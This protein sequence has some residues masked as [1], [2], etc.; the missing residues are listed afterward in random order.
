MTAFFHQFCADAADES[1][2]FA[3]ESAGCAESKADDPAKQER[4][5]TSVQ[6]TP[7]FGPP[8]ICMNLLCA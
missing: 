8:L 5:R 6:N 4:S 2:R 3:R 1:V 7:W